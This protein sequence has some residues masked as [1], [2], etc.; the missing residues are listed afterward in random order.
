MA[1]SSPHVMVPTQARMSTSQGGSDCCWAWNSTT[2]EG[3]W[4]VAP[5]VIMVLRAISASMP[6]TL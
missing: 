3:R 2:G 4:S 1:S 6:C 5:V